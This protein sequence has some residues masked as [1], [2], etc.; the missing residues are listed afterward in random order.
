MKRTVIAVVLLLSIRLIAQTPAPSANPKVRTVT[1]FVRLDRNTYEEQIA[2]TLTVLR[3]VKA[4]F[5]SSALRFDAMFIR[6]LKSAL[7]GNRR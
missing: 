1:G 7:R 4:G 5:G 3:S 2:D 6:A